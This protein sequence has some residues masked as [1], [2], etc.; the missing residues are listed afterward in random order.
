[1]TNYILSID[2]G[3][4][5]GVALV[6]YTESEPARLVKAWQLERGLAG[7]KDWTYDN[8]FFPVDGGRNVWWRDGELLAEWDIYEG[9]VTIVTEKFQ[10]INH[11][12]Y[13]LTTDSVEPLRVE[14]LLYTLDMMPDYSK[15]EKRWRRPVDQYIFGGDSKDRKKQMQ[16]KWLKENGFY[17]TGKTLGTADADDAR[18]SIAHAISYLVK[19]VHHKPTFDL[20][21]RMALR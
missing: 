12:N 13:A 10:P 11:S 16:H 19:D 7:F 15:E 14:G 5:S 17:V 20:V 21:S 9:N 18:S 2:P 1:M 4:S 8:G 6:A 3:K